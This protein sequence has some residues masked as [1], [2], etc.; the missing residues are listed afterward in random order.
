[1]SDPAAVLRLLGLARRAGALHLGSG[2]VLRALAQEGPG[3]VFLARNAGADLVRKVERD[4][5]SHRVE[6]IFDGRELAAA[7]GRDKLNVVSV[8]DPG[9]LKGIMDHLQD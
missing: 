1:L 9:F 3:M 2:P 8:H 7:F 6:R 5:A 4:A